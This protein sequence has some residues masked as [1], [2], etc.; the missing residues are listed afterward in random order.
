MNQSAL[1]QRFSGKVAVV[2]GAA[3]G[4]GFEA[5]LR[6]GREGASVVIADIAAGPAA[7]A[8]AALADEG[9]AA[10]A[11]TDDLGTMAGASAAMA[12]A[13]DRFGRLDVLVNNV[14]GTIWA[15]P[16]WHYEEAE[17]RA[18]IDRS[19]WPVMWSSRAAIDPMRASGG[20]AIVNIGSNAAAGGI[21]RIPYSAC[22]GAV[23][24]LT[25]CLA[26]ELAPLGIRVNCVSPGG[27]LAPERKTQRES[28]PFTEQEREWWAQ[29]GKLVGTEELIASRATAAQQ[30]AVI[31]F[32]ASEE[33]GHVTGE[34]V[35]TGRRGIRIGEVLGFVP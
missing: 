12:L 1:P 26:V 10:V 20:G 18:E 15:K 34:I 25:E 13:M 5:A 23:V 9:I 8:V 14:G 28:R 33:A 29:F 30:A 35:E 22:K 27:T 7:E 24:A 11:S 19:F 6:L 17:I 3:Q 16:F 31:A 21:Y 4:I 32:L 2:T